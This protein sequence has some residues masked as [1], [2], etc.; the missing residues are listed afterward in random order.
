MEVFEANLLAQ[1]LVH[2]LQPLI[3]KEELEAGSAV[4]SAAV[5]QFSGPVGAPQ[6]LVE[7]PW[8]SSALSGRGG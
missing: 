3:P 1:L 2:Q 7:V 8:R 5:P 6:E 4:Q